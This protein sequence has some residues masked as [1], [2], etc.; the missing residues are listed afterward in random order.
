MMVNRGSWVGPK[1]ANKAKIVRRAGVAYLDVNAL[2]KSLFDLLV[3]S[4]PCCKPEEE[5]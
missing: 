1:A 3:L 2:V 4:E 5:L